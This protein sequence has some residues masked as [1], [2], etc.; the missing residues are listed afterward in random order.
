MKFHR[1]FT[2]RRS[3]LLGAA[4]ITL[5]VLLACG[6]GG[7]GSDNTTP[8]GPSA[9]ALKS[10]ALA[11]AMG[12]PRRLLIGLGDGA[13]TVAEIQAQKLAP[14]IHSRYLVGRGPDSWPTW[15]SPTGAYVAAVAAD[16]TA[17]GAVPMFTLYQMADWGDGNLDSLY[18]PDYMKGYWDNVRVLFTQLRTW[19]KPALVNF[20]PDFWGYAQRL[21]N[22]PAKHYVHVNTQNPDCAD[23]PNSVA[24]MGQCL[25]KMARG[26]APKSLVGFPPSSWGDL[27]ST[28]AAY[29]RKVGA[30][31]ADFVVMQTLDRD[32]GC[33]EARYTTDNALCVRESPVP[34]YWD[35]TNAT[36]PNFTDHF[37]QAKALNEALQL[38][39]VWWQ[40]PM[41]VPST[42][43]GGT[44]GQFRDNRM[45]YF[46]THPQELV[47]AGGTAVVFSP[48]HTSQTNV[49]TDG[50]QY[51]RLSTQYLKAP[52]ALP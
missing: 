21:N 11:Q 5:S 8:P 52:A 12:K 14:D 20:E 43:P 7:G 32:A 35:A 1:F 24:G 31:Q 26:I 37:A 38:P 9:L 42:T 17:V 47:A 3:A 2:P 46:L 27:V 39:L 25:L 49:R 30:H 13:A 44:A 22:D 28:E 51:Q 33:F 45:Q 15:N 41:G 6:G 18:D 48:G 4:G 23:Q 50:G 36:R 16:A 34:F 19:N 29:L 40:T 10:G